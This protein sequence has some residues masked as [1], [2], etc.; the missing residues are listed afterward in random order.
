MPLSVAGNATATQGAMI[1]HSDQA[2]AGAP[3][4]PMSEE[5]FVHLYQIMLEVIEFWEILFHVS[6]K[7]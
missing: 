7:T 5:F 6:R 1:S 2:M 3:F 4:S